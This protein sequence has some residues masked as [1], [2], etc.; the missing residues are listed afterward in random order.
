MDE[1]RMSLREQDR[2][3]VMGR[4][5][6]GELTVVQA[7]GLLALSLRQ[8]RRVWKSF[9]ADGAKAMQRGQEPNRA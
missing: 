5:K 2:L 9:K 1:L 3:E 8:T 7:S 4:V 6:R